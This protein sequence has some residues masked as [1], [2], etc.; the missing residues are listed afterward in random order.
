MSVVGEALG[1]G[2]G[3]GSAWPGMEENLASLHS[4]VFSDGNLTYIIEPK[5]MAGPWGP[6]QVSQACTGLPALLMAV[7]QGL[8]PPPH[9]CGASSSPAVTSASLPWVTPAWVLPSVPP[10]PMSPLSPK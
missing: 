7:R 5:E 1:S 10:S 3:K 9:S 8:H 4:G 2:V 6:P